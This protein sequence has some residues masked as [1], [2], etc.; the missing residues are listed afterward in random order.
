M[1]ALG[2]FLGTLRGGRLV[3]ALVVLAL[4]LLVVARMAGAAWVEI[5]W[6][7]EAGY[8]GVFWQR[9]RWV[10]G[11]RLAG[12]VVVASLVYLNLRIASRTLGG[13]HHRRRLGTNEISVQLPRS[14]VSAGHLRA[15]G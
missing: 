15:D 5:L 6:Q 13:V 11:T 8:P 3:A 12:A 1:G 10:W 7:R 14:D 4:V 2:R 9:V